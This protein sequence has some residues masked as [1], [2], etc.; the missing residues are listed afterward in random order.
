MIF[1]DGTGVNDLKRRIYEY[2]RDMENTTSEDIHRPS[3]DADMYELDMN[4]TTSPE[5]MHRRTNEAVKFISE[6]QV[7]FS[8]QS[9]C[10]KSIN[11][12]SARSGDYSS[13]PH[14]PERVRRFLLHQN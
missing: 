5:D 6:V 12:A 8:Q 4:Y 2:Q 11:L 9:L 1:L 3:N 13:I 10:R 14:L 7:P